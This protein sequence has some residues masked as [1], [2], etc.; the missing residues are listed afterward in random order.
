[1]MISRNLGSRE[2]GFSMIEAVVVMMVSAI[3]AGFA[4]PSIRSVLYNYRLH[5]A[6]SNVTW[7]VQSTRYQA[8]MEGYP[9]QVTLSGG[10]GG[11]NP[12][13]QIASKPTGAA[14]FSNVGTSVPV[15]GSPV[16]L[17]ATTVLQFKPNGSVSATTGALNF[18]IVY[19]GSTETITVTNY[20]NVTVTP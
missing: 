17:S 3:L 11:I 8:L 10:T 7:A 9:F 1:M 16:N 14:S 19:Q 13:Y 12:S 15:S 20:G 4:V 6:V 2:K 18:N 5:A